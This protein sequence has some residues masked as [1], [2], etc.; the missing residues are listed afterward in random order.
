MFIRFFTFTVRF[1][2]FA[3]FC[4]FLLSLLGE[5]FPNVWDDLLHLLQH[6]PGLIIELHV[7]LLSLMTQ[8]DQLGKVLES[9]TLT[10][11]F[12]QLL[13]SQ[14]VTSLKCGLADILK[15][16][17]YLKEHYFWKIIYLPEHTWLHEVL[18]PFLQHDLFRVDLINKMWLTIEDEEEVG[19]LLNISPVMKGWNIGGLGGLFENSGKMF[20]VFFVI[21]IVFVIY[22]QL[23]FF[24][25]QS[26]NF[27]LC[28]FSRRISFLEKYFKF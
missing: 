9:G 22:L 6:K 1:Q 25:T 17:E 4:P 7:L 10:A 27:I 20:D 26:K 16:C 15:N 8:F 13:I 18:I 21:Q 3:Q 23:C 11:E 24:S 5:W 19:D 12:L 14:K 28:S 2:L